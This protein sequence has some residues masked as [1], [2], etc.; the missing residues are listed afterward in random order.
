MKVFSTSFTLSSEERT[1]VSDITK[2]VRDAVQQFPVSAGIALVNTL[3]TTCALFVNEFQSA[4]IED[5]K[6]L[7]ERLVPERSGYRH[8]DPR[9][10]DCERG[11]A[12]AHL[13]AALLGR[14]IAVALNHGELT[15]GRFQSIIFA[16]FDG[17]RRR[18]ISVQVIGE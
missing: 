17:P 15:L 16:E 13:R 11:N 4:L 1:E 5:L 14:N 12:H 6:A 10:S 9:V 18:E 3:H 2:L 8:D 7:A